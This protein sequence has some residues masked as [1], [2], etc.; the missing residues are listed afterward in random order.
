[1]PN[2]I[3]EHKL[4]KLSA[5]MFFFPRQCHAAM[6]NA[7]NRTLSRVAT[8]I[9]KEVAVDY[10]V[11]RNQVK[12]TIGLKK[13]RVSTLQAE[14][15]VTDTRIKMGSFA[16]KVLDQQYRTPVSVKIKKSNGFVKSGSQ[17]PVF[18]GMSRVTGKK[19]LFH[20]TPGD[21]YKMG[22]AFTLSIPQMVANDDVYDRIQKDAKEFLVAR[23]QHELE[24]QLN[25][26]ASKID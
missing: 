5:E 21:A 16:F 7:L 6:N 23:Y 19:E 1:M 25:K 4:D 26:L 20:R 10:A 22:Y 18:A 8:N 24:Y 17:P 9:T 13:S 15:T 14:A 12:K 3:V 11:K 2:V